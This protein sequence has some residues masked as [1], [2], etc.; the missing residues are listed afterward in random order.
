MKVV[1]LQ[2]VMYHFPLIYNAKPVFI[3][4]HNF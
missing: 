3:N 2:G 4:M 1:I